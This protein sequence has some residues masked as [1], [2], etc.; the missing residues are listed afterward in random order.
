MVLI[1]GHFVTTQIEALPVPLIHTRVT[2]EGSYLSLPVNS[3]IHSN[4]I[5]F[6]LPHSSNPNH[7]QRPDRYE[8]GTTG[9]FAFHLFSYESCKYSV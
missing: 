2:T 7:P 3:L 1:C 5:Q 4:P 9:N 6:Q 8:T